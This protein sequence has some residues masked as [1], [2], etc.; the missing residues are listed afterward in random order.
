[1]THILLTGSTGFIGRQVLRELLSNGLKVSIVVRSDAHTSKE[2][3][4]VFRTKDLFCS[5]DNFWTKAFRGVDVFMH[6]AWYVEPGEYLNSVE[7][8]T[9]MAGT[10]RLAKLAAEA[11]V[12][13]F[14]GI[15]T[16]FEYDLGAGYLTTSTP[17]RPKSVYGASKAGTYLALSQYLPRKNVSFVWCRLFYVYGEGEDPRRLAAYVRSR[18]SAGKHVEI[19]SGELI[20]DYM[21]VKE[22]GKQIAEVAISDIEEAVNICSGSPITVGE[23]AQRIATECGRPELLQIGKSSDKSD[24]PICVIGKPSLS[25]TNRKIT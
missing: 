16:C 15:G 14:V 21:D 10:V 24:E 13:R 1:M 20:R 5:P 19:R 22:V 3:Y 4:Q 8:L 17:L 18:V 12:K 7:N 2:V 11:G 23:F 6:I 9:C 25:Q